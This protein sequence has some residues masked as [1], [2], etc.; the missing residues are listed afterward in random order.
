M[1]WTR[2]WDIEMKVVESD[3]GKN[4]LYLT[5]RDRLGRSMLRPYKS[6]TDA[7]ARGNYFPV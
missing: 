2:N 6:F 7:S 5:R 4:G 1:S 3:A